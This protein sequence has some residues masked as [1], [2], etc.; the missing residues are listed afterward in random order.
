MMQCKLNKGNNT[1]VALVILQSNTPLRRKSTFDAYQPMYIS[2]KGRR[3][4]NVWDPNGE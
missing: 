3:C 2:R 4:V 1:K